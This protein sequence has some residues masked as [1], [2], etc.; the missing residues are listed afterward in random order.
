V[1]LLTGHLGNFE[2]MGASLARFNPVDFVTQPLSN[3]GAERWIADLRRA[4]G[5]GTLSTHGGVKRVF[6]ALRAGRWVAM[7]A[8]QDARSR[9][10]FVPFFG[11]PASTPEGPAR[12]ALATGAPIVFGSCVRRDDGRHG[13]R[14]APPLV[15]EGD[16]RDVEAVRT[17]TARHT[18]IL[19]DAVRERP[20][21][22]F[23]LHRR[24]KT[25]PPSP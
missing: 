21:S 14:V 3:P 18:A 19:E 24:W 6:T 16:A 1:I 20:A 7:L 22:W 5:V 13:L 25:A 9:G 17:L 8:D 15:P 11:R 4:C 10:V 2:L 12:I 23:W